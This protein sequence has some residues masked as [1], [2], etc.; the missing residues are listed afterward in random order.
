VTRTEERLLGI[1]VIA[2]SVLVMVCWHP[3]I[4]AIGVLTGISMTDPFC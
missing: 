1:A 3:I 4:G 2:L